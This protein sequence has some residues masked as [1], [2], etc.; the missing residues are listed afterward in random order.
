MTALGPGEI[1][2]RKRPLLLLTIAG[3]RILTG[4]CLALPL[5][6][7]VSSSGVGLRAEGDRALF[8]GGG[9]LLL[10]LVRLQGSNLVAVM[11]GLLPLLLLGLLLTAA[12]N[13]ALL[14]AL[15]ARE[16]LKSLS[17]LASAWARL[18]ALVVLGAGTAVAQGLVIIVGA[19]GS[20]AVPA[21]LARPQLT[22]ALQAL[23]WL[24]T[25]LL[26][27]GVGGFADS[28]KASLV[29]YDAGLPEGLA[30]AWRCLLRR[31]IRAC[32]GWLPYAAAF[33][34][35]VLLVTKLTEAIDVSR[36][37]GWRIMAVFSAHQLV[38]VTSVALRAAW[39][40]RALRF[41]A[42]ET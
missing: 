1:R 42:I 15:N 25:L 6:A 8:E 9:Y 7:L 2:A 31:P 29:R 21:W 38:I 17:W 24:V 18:P 34:V 30:R 27:A 19:L 28:T 22:T 4:F 16:R 23:V 12:C 36:A 20:D 33:V 41:V 35:S 26:A 40:A 11:R 14:V 37:G 5:S 13:A 3:L 32:F 39:F 10:D